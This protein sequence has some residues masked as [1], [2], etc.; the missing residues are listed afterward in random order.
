M[1]VKRRITCIFGL[2]GSGKSTLANYICE[3]FGGKALYYDTVAEVPAG[4]GYDHYRPTNRQG[5]AAGVAELEATI[6]AILK[7][8]RYSLL[9]IDE[10]NRFAPPKPSPLPPAI[11]DLNDICRHLSGDG[12]GV[13]FIA[14][15]PVQ[16]NQDITE[17]ADNIIIYRLRGRNDI[18][19]LDDLA[20]G[21][22]QA[23]AGLGDYEYALVDRD[24]SFRVMPP[25]PIAG[26]WQNRER[27]HQQT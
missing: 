27:R 16:L 21:L 22:G 8:R 20:D 1:R 9:A 23:V 12:L 3:S 24:R 19:Y 11:A 25:V 15:R 5:D 13:I 18:G 7:S 4:A 10:A 2:R 26:A 6:K 14:R 17:L